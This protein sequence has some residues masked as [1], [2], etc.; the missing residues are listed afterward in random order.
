MLL[1]VFTGYLY[2]QKVGY[3]GTE[4]EPQE[5]RKKEDWGMAV[6]KLAMQKTEKETHHFS[7]LKMLIYFQ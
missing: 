1:K 7:Q 4:R 5:G 6:I 2:S 3:Q